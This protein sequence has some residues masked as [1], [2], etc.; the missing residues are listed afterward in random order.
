MYKKPH[1]NQTTKRIFSLI[2][3]EAEEKG[4]CSLS[5]E[6]MQEK[7]S[8]S[9]KITLSFH[10]ANLENSGLVKRIRTYNLELKR[11]ERHLYLTD[12]TLEDYLK[13]N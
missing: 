1:F 4:F 8:I 12:L 7:L 6:A 3:S 11:P 13:E 9:N 2:L 10:I 5:N